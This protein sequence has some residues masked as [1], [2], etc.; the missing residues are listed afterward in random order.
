MREH[1]ESGLSDIR[2]T[3]AKPGILARPTEDSC[4]VTHY[5]HRNGKRNVGHPGRLS[6]QPATLFPDPAAA[7]PG[8]AALVETRHECA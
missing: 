7:V 6:G 3:L 2:R 5:I 8:A 4:F 1:W